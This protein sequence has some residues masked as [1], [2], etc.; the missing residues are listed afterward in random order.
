MRTVIRGNLGVICITA[1]LFFALGFASA[2]AY[3]AYK[4]N[5]ERSNSFH[6]E[7]TVNTQEGS[8]PSAGTKTKISFIRYYTKDGGANVTQAENTSEYIGKNESWF[9]ET[10]PD[11][12]IVKFTTEEITLEKTVDSHSPDSYVLST[13]N[14][15]NGYERLAVYSYDKEGMR[16]LY[17][18]YDTPAEMFEQS[19]LERLRGGIS[20]KGKEELNKLLQNYEE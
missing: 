18:L 7:K 20:V 12:H 15:E 17:W 16:F 4:Y 13:A 10:F 8:A 14:D 1:A 5:K 9:A 19:E 3:D 6:E 2:K 11:W